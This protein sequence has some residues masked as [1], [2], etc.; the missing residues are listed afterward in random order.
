[1][2]KVLMVV[3][4]VGLIALMPLIIFTSPAESAPKKFVI[5]T[6]TEPDI[7]EGLKAIHPPVTRPI[8][9]NIQEFLVSLNTE[10]KVVP[11]LSSSWT[12]S[13]DG[14]LIDFTLQ[15]GIKF[16]SGDPLTTKDVVFSFNRGNE[17]NP[18]HQRYLRFLD[19]MEIIDDYRIKFHFKEAD[20]TFLKRLGSVPIASK[21]YFDRVGEDQ[22]T[23]RP[24]G[25]GPYQFVAWELGNFIDLKAF[26]DYWGSAPS[27]KEVRFKFAKEDTTRVA[28]LK[29]GEADLV[30]NIPYPNV[31]EIKKAGFKTVMFDTHPTMQVRFQCFN[32]K[33]PWYDKRVRKAVALAIDSDAIIKKLFHGI[34]ARYARIAPWELGYDPEL[35]PYPYDPKKAKQLLAEAGYPNGFEMPWYYLIGRG[36]GIKETAE[37]SAL[38]LNAVGIKCKVTGMEGIKLIAMVKDEWRNNPNAVTVLGVDLAPLAH[39][40]D[41]SMA[42]D[43]V[44]HSQ[45]PFCF[46]STP[47]VDGLIDKM[48]VTVDDTKRAELIKKANRI[49]DEEVPTIEHWA[50]RVV[51]GMKKNLDFTPANA[52]GILYMHVNDIKVKE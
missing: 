2:K 44:Y 26:E 41:P 49:I 50:S 18:I 6:E 16:H 34:P 35:K 9:D 10:G 12:V 3:V 51:Y 36:A 39:Y 48:K 31:E 25:T 33:V 32:P 45:A 8:G 11:C 40:P 17:I 13:P 52:T 5:A 23:R 38:Y 20:A 30:M 4:V 21:S 28:M 37:A 14:K 29:T 22:F 24:V 47:E 19:K 46:W 7:L 1:M 42:L 27:I 15:K 43:M